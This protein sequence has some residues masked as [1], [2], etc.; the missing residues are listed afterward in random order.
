MPGFAAENVVEP[1]DWD[2]APYVS[3][4]GTIPEPTDKQIAEFLTGMKALVKEIQADIPDMEA[5][6]PAVIFQAME[7]LDPAKTIEAVGKMCTVYAALCSGTPSA[8]QIQ[9][10][11]MRVRTIFF[12]WLQAEVM[13]PEA[14]SPGGNGQ[15]RSLP[16]ARGA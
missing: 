4:R 3:A 12:S 11:P 10:L 9:A 2:F 15:V 13:S 8:E 14:V 1:L 7:D 16:I 5:T 6:D